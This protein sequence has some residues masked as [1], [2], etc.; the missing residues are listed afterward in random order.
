MSCFARG[1]RADRPARALVATSLAGA[2]AVAPFACNSGSSG[3]TSRA[4]PVLT[5]TP[6]EG[7]LPG[8]LYTES[9][10]LRS[11]DGSLFHGRG[12]S[13]QDTRSCNACTYQAPDANEV[14]RRADS[15]I[16]DW[17]A[18]F[19]RLTLESYATAAGRTQWQTVTS[20]SGY[21]A[22][23]VA[24]TDHFRARGV[25]V[26][27]S[28]WSDPSFTSMGWPTTA[29]SEEWALLAGAF[30]DNPYVLYGVANEPQANLDGT[31]DSQV[32]DAM[33]Q[34]VQTLRDTE[35]PAGP[36]HI[37]AVQGTGG[38]A[39]LLGYY[40]SHPITAGG[41]EN[42][43]YEEHFYDPASLLQTQLVEP[44]ETLPVIVGEFGPADRTL[45]TMTLP[46]CVQLL[47]AAQA[48]DLPWLAWTFHFRC[49]PNLLVDQSRDMCGIG[50]PL[51]ATG[52]WGALIKAQL[53]APW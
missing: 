46:D 45:A 37:V 13:L 27:V 51:V 36:H 19:V 2:L 39:R 11:S 21:L 44:A 43:V 17:H 53:S 52:D 10:H 4:P 49:P 24:I 5:S 23:L 30:Q 31:F 15:L 12:A 33:N 6:G 42:V 9:N 3:S 25:Y 18:T 38:W 32:W 34:V 7:G 50:T 48:H 1:M 28:L 41:G 40:V 14:I 26:L 29:T 8:W 20:D 16:D 22:D 35:P 47:A